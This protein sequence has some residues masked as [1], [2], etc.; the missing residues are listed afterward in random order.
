MTEKAKRPG[1]D[2]VGAQSE[3]R[4]WCGQCLELFPGAACMVVCWEGC[5]YLHHRAS[6]DEDM[7]TFFSDSKWK[8][9][10]CR[11][12]ECHSRDEM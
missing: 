3:V 7:L 9:P 5:V 4:S 1:P 12:N 6:R 8:S 10:V 11:E 2:R